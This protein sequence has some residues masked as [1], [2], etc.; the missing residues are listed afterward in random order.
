MNAGEVILTPESLRFVPPELPQ[1]AILR[2]L[3]D[4][5]GLTGTLEPLE[6]ERDQN[7]RLRTSDG[8]LYV[9]KVSSLQEDPAVIDFQ[10]SAL[11]HLQKKDPE[12]PAPRLLRTQR[13]EVL[14][15]VQDPDERPHPL[16]VLGYLPGIPFG[17]S[18][19]SLAGL[20]KIGAFQGRV[21]RALADFQHKAARHFMP[22]DI[23]NGLVFN[24]GLF[25]EA[26]A[27]IQASVSRFL[28]HLQ[29]VTFPALPS[30]RRQVIHND[31][32]SYNLLRADAQSEE[33]IGIIDFGDMIEA[34]LIQ[35]VAVSMA[36][37]IR[38]QPLQLEAIASIAKGF[39][40][41]Y[42]FEDEEFDVVYDLV[43]LRLVVALLLID[44]RL[45]ISASPDAEL[46]AENQMV[47]ETLGS[48]GDLERAAVAAYLREA[49]QMRAR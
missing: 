35:D 48:F 43:I 16:R 24:K 12:L 34:P 17:E 11:L 32:H 5:Y 27:D 15:H 10:I 47:M 19:P 3:E 29:S 18:C 13:G 31:C 40:R 42:P 36:S 1:E 25:D 9:S 7:H 26:G 8:A 39:H 21:S 46:A 49:C 6:G 37:F 41:V 38:T 14:T 2:V 4:Q 44:Y 28:P 30:L 33:L 23:S 45:R 20:E 22:W